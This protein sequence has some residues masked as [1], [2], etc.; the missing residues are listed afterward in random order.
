MNANDDAASLIDFSQIDSL[1]EVAGRD[2]VGDILGAFWRS[3]DDLARQLKTHIECKNLG[4]AAR[5]SHAVKGS[6][7]NVGA[8]LL[9][10][11]A[12]DVETCCKNN[13]A[14]GALAALNCLLS[15]YRRTQVAL[16]ERVA[17]Y[18]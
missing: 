17:A 11:V 5:A 4:E 13:D 14:D 1:L 18:R 12:R 7:A 6:A 2:G 8:A 16:T 3:T 10:N 15:A 9:A